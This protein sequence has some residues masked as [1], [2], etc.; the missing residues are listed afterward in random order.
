LDRI[1]KVE[2]VTLW[3]YFTCF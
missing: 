1:P 3:V 2:V